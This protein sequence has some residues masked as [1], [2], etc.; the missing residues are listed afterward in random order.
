MGGGQWGAPYFEVMNVHLNG[1]IKGPFVTN[2]VEVRHLEH[3]T[4]AHIHELL[5]ALLGRGLG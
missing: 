3:H 1:L 5:H 2:T 4:V